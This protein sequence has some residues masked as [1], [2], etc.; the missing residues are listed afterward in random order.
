[1]G[2]A[3]NAVSSGQLDQVFKMTSTVS[4]PMQSRTF[5]KHQLQEVPTVPSILPAASG[6]SGVTINRIRLSWRSPWS[7]PLQTTDQYLG[8][9]IADIIQC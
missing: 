2:Q 9:V 6:T 8:N 4:P 7:L 1:M 5:L 3:D